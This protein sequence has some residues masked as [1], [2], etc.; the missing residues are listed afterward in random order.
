MPTEQVQSE[1]AVPAA[2][3]GRV[4]LSERQ[5]AE[6]EQMIY[7][8]SDIPVD[9]QNA[10]VARLRQGDAT[11][12]QD[13]MSAAAGYPST[14]LVFGPEVKFK[15]GVIAAI[16]RFKKKKTHN[17]TTM[18]RLAAMRELARDLGLVYN[19][20]NEVK[21]AAV[22]LIEDDDADSRRS[23]YHPRTNT[24]VMVEKLSIITL[25]HEFAHALGKDEAGAVRWS[26]TL[27]QRVW[28]QQFER[29][30]PDQHT[31]VLPRH[32]ADDGEDVAPTE[33]TVTE[34]SQD[35]EAEALALMENEDEN[36]EDI[37]EE[38]IDEEDFD[39]DEEDDDEP[40]PEPE[41]APRRR[42]TAKKKETAKPKAKKPA[43]PKAKPK[44]KKKSS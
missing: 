27:F 29:L 34:A 14:P 4:R 20:P 9:Q 28:P 10:L 19:L 12:V 41:P 2:G 5:I 39:D 32:E 7:G 36:E 15:L 25:L 17:R 8:S 11:V 24:I 35:E 18:E 26:L 21:V 37:D 40:E 23:F 3:Q 44:A 31:M 6:I 42:R 22:C 30:Q 33:P 13:I 16:K 1:V 43:K 38:W